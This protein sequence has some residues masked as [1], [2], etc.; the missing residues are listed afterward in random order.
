VFVTFTGHMALHMTLVA[1]V[2]PAAAAWLAR[3]RL[4][5]ARHFPRAFSPIA[6]SLVEFVVV[7]GWHLPALH[8]TA[9]HHAGW[10]AAEQIAFLCASLF[11]WLSIVGGVRQE[12]PARAAAGVIALVL[13]FA[14]M[15][16]L[17]VL[18]ALAPRDLYGHRSDGIADQQMGGG[19]MI[20]VA[21]VV[22]LGAALWL[23]RSLVVG[24]GRVEARP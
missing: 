3:T 5:P 18:I 17:G 23:S 6:A 8:L 4:D 1:V 13:T 12:R 7:W 20:A 22:Y 11:L 10:F 21:V 16:M 19:V 9:R 15:T 2:A 14:H 24:S